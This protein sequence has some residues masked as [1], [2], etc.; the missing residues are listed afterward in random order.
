MSIGPH[1]FG[2]LQ[3]HLPWLF[4]LAAFFLFAIGAASETKMNLIVKRLNRKRL[5]RR[6]FRQRFITSIQDSMDLTPNSIPSDLSDS[7]PS[8][9]KRLL[10]GSNWPQSV[11]MLARF[12]KKWRMIT[13]NATSLARHLAGM[14]T[15]TTKLANDLDQAWSSEKEV[16]V[17]QEQL[18]QYKETVEQQRKRKLVEDL[19]RHVPPKGSVRLWANFLL[20]VLVAS[21]SL[22][23]W[24]ALEDHHKIVLLQQQLHDAEERERKQNE[25][26]PNTIT[27]HGLRVVERTEECCF[28]AWVMNPVTKEWNLAQYNVCDGPL[29][30]TTEIQSGVTIKEF[31]YQEDR[32]HLCMDISSRFAGYT[33]ERN[34]EGRT[35][36]ASIEKPSN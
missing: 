31:Q 35:I 27:V 18:A 32:K 5:N 10:A 21:W 34:H 26:P 20:A 3:H 12:E 22:S 23:G 25:V 1:L 30:L 11:A 28:T 2:S 33:L 36:L 4:I 19:K 17:I 9:K 24:M 16:Q 7:P 29:P 14:R 6:L 13:A 15:A 8:A